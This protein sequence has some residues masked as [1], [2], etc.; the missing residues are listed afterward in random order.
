[1]NDLDTSYSFSY[2]QQMNASHAADDGYGNSYYSSCEDDIRGDQVI[3]LSHESENE[4]IFQGK[5]ICDSADNV[6]FS[7]LSE[8]VLEYFQILI[9]H[10]EDVNVDSMLEPDVEFFAFNTNVHGADLIDVNVEV[11][12]CGEQV[13]NA[14][15]VPNSSSMCCKILLHDEDRRHGL[16]GDYFKPQMEVF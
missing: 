16:C 12:P 5:N 13:V 3:Y 15:E 1:M 11:S 10:E 2:D 4:S 9:Y 8:P 6:L 14:D 7:D